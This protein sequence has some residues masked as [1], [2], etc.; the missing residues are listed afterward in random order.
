MALTKD[1]LQQIVAGLEPRFDELEARLT[2]K[3]DQA[4]GDLAI[5]TQQQFLAIDARFDGVDARLD[6]ID[7]RLDGI[8]ERLNGIDT[9]LGNMED[10]MV[11][12]KDMVKDHGFRITKQEHRRT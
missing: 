7:V 6:G 12:V 11:V 5:A 3:I 4:V 1:D 2:R 8:D 9:R 10:D